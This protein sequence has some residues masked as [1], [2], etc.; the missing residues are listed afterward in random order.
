MILNGLLSINK[1]PSSEKVLPEPKGSPFKVPEGAKMIG[2]YLLGI[3]F[4]KLGKNI[5]QGSFGKV[6]LGMH[7]PT[8]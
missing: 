5:G 8:G 6:H 2:N 7:I 3:I 1:P 4:H